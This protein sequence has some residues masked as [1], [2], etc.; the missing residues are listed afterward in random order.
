M[1]MKRISRLFNVGPNTIVRKVFRGALVPPVG[2]F[3]SKN[4]PSMYFAIS[5]LFPFLVG[6]KATV[7]QK[8]R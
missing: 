8:V 2:R 1:N 7:L 6:Q 3:F 5:A 4:V